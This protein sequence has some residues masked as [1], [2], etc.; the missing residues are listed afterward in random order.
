MGT[1]PSVDTPD[2]TMG[3]PRGPAVASSSAPTG[4]SNYLVNHQ[5]AA[6]LKS[7]WRACCGVGT[8]WRESH[9]NKHYRP[10]RALVTTPVSPVLPHVLQTPPQSPNFSR[11]ITAPSSPS[12]QR[13]AMAPS[14]SPHLPRVFLGTPTSAPSTPTYSVP[15]DISNPMPQHRPLPAYSPTLTRSSSFNSSCHH[16]SK[17]LSMPLSSPPGSPELYRD[18]LAAR[19]AQSMS[20]SSPSGSPRLKRRPLPR[21]NALTLD[22][23]SSPEICN[24]PCCSPSSSPSLCLT[25]EYE[26]PEYRVLI[27]ECDSSTSSLSSCY[28]LSDCSCPTNSHGFSFPQM[29]HSPSFPQMD[30]SPS[31][32]QMDHSPSFPKMDHSPSFHQ[33]DHSPSFPQMDHSPVPSPPTSPLVSFKYRERQLTRSRSAP[34]SKS[35]KRYFQQGN[36]S[37]VS[38]QS[39]Q[40]PPMEDDTI[41][42]ALA[43]PLVPFS[44]REGHL[45]RSRSTSPSRG[46]M[47]GRP[48]TPVSPLASP[49]LNR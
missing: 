26:S 44:R 21:Q 32:P 25:P 19:R 4:G 2:A 3:A 7:G 48:F 1:G 13:L 47:S 14:Y 28:S 37:P 41:P 45:R 17:T 22:I 39:F 15:I 8:W 40:F 35:P 43:S 38:A 6:N 31:F 16:I 12:A 11:V 9:H 24:S 46:L 33:M 34:E 49:V 30:H 42:S 18:S 23:S 29:D 20:L 36:V 27:P 5:A 10:L